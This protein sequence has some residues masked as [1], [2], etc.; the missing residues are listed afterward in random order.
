MQLIALAR[1]SWR[2][3]RVARLALST[4]GEHKFAG[5]IGA[6]SLFSTSLELLR[7]SRAVFRRYFVWNGSK[8]RGME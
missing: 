2:F 7:Q 5:A 3:P 8:L 4:F 6:R 1:T